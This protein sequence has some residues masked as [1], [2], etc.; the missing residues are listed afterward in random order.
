ML[1]PLLRLCVDGSTHCLP[2]NVVVEA[3]AAYAPRA[4]TVRPGELQVRGMRCWYDC[5]PGGQ[6]KV[7]NQAGLDAA[8]WC[9]LTQP[10]ALSTQPGLSLGTLE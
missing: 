8:G 9:P 3:F 4:W 6:E 1:L 10:C 2:K 7:G 5:G